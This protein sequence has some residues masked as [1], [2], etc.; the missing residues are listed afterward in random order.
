MKDEK[1]IPYNPHDSAIHTDAY[2]LTMAY[3]QW[4]N[5]RAD[6]PASFDYYTRKCTFGGAYLITGGLE[7]T[8]KFLNS[9]KFTSEMIDIVK[10]RVLP[11]A[12]PKFFDYLHSL[13]CSKVLLYAP[14]EGTLMFPNE[15]LMRVDTPIA[16][17]HLLET[18]ILNI[19][20]FPSLI[21]TLSSHFRLSAGKEK[22]L[23]EFALRRTQGPDG[24]LTASEFAYMGGF[25]ATSNVLAGELF[26]IPV[27][28]TMA[29]AYIQSFEGLKQIRDPY[30]KTADGI[31]VNFALLVLEKRQKFGFTETNDGEL[32]AFITYAQAFPDKFL[33]L[34]DTY[35]IESGIKNFICVALALKKMGYKA[36][37]IRI[38][39]GDL[40]YESKKAKQ[41]FAEHSLNDASVV[42]SNDINL[43]VLDEFKKQNYELDVLGIGTN[44]GTA[45]LEPAFPGVYKL[46]EIKGK[47]RI[48]LSKSKKTIPGRKEIFRLYDSKG[49]AVDDLLMLVGENAPS[50]GIRT[51]CLDPFS[52]EAVYVTPHK[53]KRLHHLYWDRGRV[54]E[55][56]PTIHEKRAYVL[57]QL[58]AFREDHLRRVNPTP[59]KVSVSRKLKDLMR[60]LEETEK[61][62]KEIV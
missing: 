7:K 32:A 31:N 34:I 61:P 25:D 5:G 44:L 21:A 40:A 6:E 24:G 13:D 17:G 30:L 20:N 4:E 48:K 9:F 1:F 14:P 27:S 28:G 15:P 16:M 23:L 22:K 18:R 59:Y 29:H 51:S 45:A 47:P 36:L 58:E 57:K 35:D 2:Q 52:S 38:D 50:K 39:S 46:M 54:T 62:I 41:M 42:G 12:N 43:E 8:L 11:H 55:K 37:G 3:A 56:L 26:D 19:N 60:T 49:I 33:A 53:V 10:R